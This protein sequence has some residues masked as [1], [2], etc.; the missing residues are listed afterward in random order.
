ML[1]EKTEGVVLDYSL[2]T[3]ERS[4]TDKPKKRA[5]SV[6]LESRVKASPPLSPN[7]TILRLA[8]QGY[9][10]RAKVEV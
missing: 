10:R 2:R 1:A 5:F 3:R 8:H 7:K 6:R 4:P 9:W